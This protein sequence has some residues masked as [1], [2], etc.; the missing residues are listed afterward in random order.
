MPQALYG[1]P[2]KVV[3]CKKTLISNQRPFS[4][5]EFKNNNLQKKKTTFIDHNGISDPWKF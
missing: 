5:I 3:F 1:L 2:K 4:S